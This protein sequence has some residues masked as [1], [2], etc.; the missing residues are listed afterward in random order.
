MS[1]LLGLSYA[2]YRCPDIRAVL[3]E[4]HSCVNRATVSGSVIAFKI[5]Y[6]GGVRCD[7][8][9]SYV[10]FSVFFCGTPD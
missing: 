10:S 3:F 2:L 8:V 7:S 5:R 9:D 6:M 1:N 4:H